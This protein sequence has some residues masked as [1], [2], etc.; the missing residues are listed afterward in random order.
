MLGDHPDPPPVG[1]HHGHGLGARPVGPHDRAVTVGVDPEDVV[2][3][4]VFAGHDLLHLDGDRVD[5]GG[6]RGG[7]AVSGLGRAGSGSFRVA[8]RRSSPAAGSAAGR[9]H[10]DGAQSGRLARS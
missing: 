7:R 6:R 8:I 5:L 4:G 2:G 9:L 1:Q 3:I 10:G